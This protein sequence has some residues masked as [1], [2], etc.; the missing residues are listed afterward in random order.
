MEAEIWTAVEMAWNTE[1]GKHYQ[2]QWA[3]EPDS[4]FWYDVGT[5]ITGT[6]LRLYIFES[7]RGSTKKY[8]RVKKLD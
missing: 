2:I 4:G 8:Y 6:G 3:S 7:I 5:P 1:L